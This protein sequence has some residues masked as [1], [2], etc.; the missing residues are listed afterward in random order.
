MWLINLALVVLGFL[1]LGVK[2]MGWTIFSSFALSLYVSIC[3]WLWPITESLS[4]DTMLYL[5]FA[6]LLP[7]LG[8]A[9]VF[10]IGV[11]SP[12]AWI[13][14]PSYPGKVYLYG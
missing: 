12:A 5:V 4:G 6:A 9:I 10:G 7:A 11:L 2:C 13:M 8:S 3:E 14:W 1:F